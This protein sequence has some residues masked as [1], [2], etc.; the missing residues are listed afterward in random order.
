MRIV[1]QTFENYM[2][3]GLVVSWFLIS[4]VYLFYCEKRKSRRIIFVYMPLAVLLLFFNPLCS[5]LFLRMAEDEIYYR[6]LWLLPVLAG[7]AY[8]VCHI[9][10]HTEGKRRMV[11]VFCAVAVIAFS[12]KFVYDSPYFSKA[13]N[14]YHVPDSVVHICDAI[15]VPGR[16][17]MAAFPLEMVQYVRQYTAL[18]CMP[19]GREVLTGFYNPLQAAMEEDTVDLAEL[20]PMARAYKCHYLVFGAEQDFTEEPA[21]LGL[22]VFLET[23][24]YTVYRDT[25]IELIV[26]QM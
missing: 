17:V 14:S 8:T 26:P 15:V 19:Y 16:E 21:G 3:T 6:I 12:G 22:E 25:A 11:F 4:A 20:L 5:A 7:I 2:G 13:E 9:Y 10:S 23:D 1:F 18:V 24:G